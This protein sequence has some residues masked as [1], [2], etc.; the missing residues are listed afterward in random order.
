MTLAHPSLDEVIARAEKGRMRPPAW[1]L[2][3]LTW[4]PGLAGS[5]MLPFVPWA[6]N[7]S[8]LTPLRVELLLTRSYVRMQTLKN[9]PDREGAG[10]RPRLARAL[11]SLAFQKSTRKALVAC[12]RM[13]ADSPIGS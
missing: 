12:S 5:P 1:P 10:A 2:S 4:T 6:L 7:H 9:G 8:C 3:A 11:A 13:S